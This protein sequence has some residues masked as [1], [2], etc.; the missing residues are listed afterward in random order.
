MAYQDWAVNLGLFDSPQPYLL[1]SIPS[2]M[3]RFQLAAEGHG[4]RQPPDRLR[5]RIK[6]A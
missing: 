3:R 5:D 1:R 4:D 6:E 2:R